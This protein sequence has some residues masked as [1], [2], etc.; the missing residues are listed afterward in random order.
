MCARD[1]WSFICGFNAIAT[2]KV[3]ITMTT[4]HRSFE[5]ISCKYLQKME[6]GEYYRTWDCPHFGKNQHCLELL[7]TDRTDCDYS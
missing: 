1:I 6:Y 4:S 2:K 3:F 5:D 7:Q